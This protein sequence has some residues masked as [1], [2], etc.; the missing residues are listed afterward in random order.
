MLFTLFEFIVLIFSVIVHEV[1]HGA[2]ARV[3]GDKTAEEAGR[4]TLNPIKHIDMVG[5]LLLP[6]ALLLLG[7]PV[8]FGWAK[9][10][11]YDP[12]NLRNPRSGAALIGAAGPVSNLLLAAIFAVI[13][14]TLAAGGATADTPMLVL[15][16][17]I[18]YINCLLAIFNL[19]PL[20]PLD[21]SNILLSLLPRRV[22]AIRPFVQRYTLPLLLIFVFF[23]FRLIVPVV[24]GVYG[25][26]TGAAATF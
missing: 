25:L 17:I 23:G 4:L 26:L 2:L 20:P 1:S 11:P 19:V 9:P 5:S 7:S 13:A 14:R 8:L 10:V 18:V 12:R 3:L 6:G 21:G 16:N 15:T 22:E 24:Q